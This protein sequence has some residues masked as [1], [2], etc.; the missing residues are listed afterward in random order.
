LAE[1]STGLAP[2]SDMT[3]NYHLMHPGN[4]QKSRDMEVK[5]DEPGLSGSAEQPNLGTRQT[6]MTQGQ[7]TRC[8]ATG[9]PRA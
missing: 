4:D 3:L 6:I 5:T 8:T 9:K 7:P 1:E 2:M